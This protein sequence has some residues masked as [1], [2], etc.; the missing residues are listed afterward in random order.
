MQ[1]KGRSPARRS[2]PS[3]RR[4]PGRRLTALGFFY[5]RDQGR[6]AARGAVRER[7]D[8][9]PKIDDAE[10]KW[11]CDVPKADGKET[12]TKDIKDVGDFVK[13][14]VEPAMKGR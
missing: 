6:H 1:V 4:E 7:Q 10:A 13:F 11:Q 3:S 9:A 2:C 8:A 12:E 14:C 5:R